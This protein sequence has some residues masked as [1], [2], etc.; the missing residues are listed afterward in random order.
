MKLKC[1]RK[2]IE[3]LGEGDSSI[4][5]QI[6]RSCESLRH[7]DAYITIQSYPVLLIRFA[8]HSYTLH[9]LF[10]FFLACPITRRSLSAHRPLTPICN[11]FSCTLYTS[12]TMP[13]VALWL[14]WLLSKFLSAK[15]MNLIM[16][17]IFTADGLVA[18]FVPTLIEVIL[19]P[20]T[21][22][23][24]TT[25]FPTR[26]AKL[27]RIFFYYSWQSISGMID[28]G[29]A[30][31]KV[32]VIQ[33]AKGVVLEIGAGLGVNIKYY[34]RELVN[35]LILVE[36]NLAMHPLLLAEANKYKYYEND[37]SLLLL[38]CGGAA[39][40]EKELEAAGVMANSIDTVACIHGKYRHT[41]DCEIA[42][43]PQSF[44]AS[45]NQ[46]LPSRCTSVY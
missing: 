21:Y 12:A 2:H 17:L 19:H 36:P 32:P 9:D 45:Q 35:Q 3:R 40:D 43:I 39:S 37:G 27:R 5:W 44:A 10:V 31:V 4:S 41:P 11:L 13:A 28:R 24:T 1:D 16:P 30:E 33:K 18:G 23:F 29:D 38:G 42:N 8:V 26:Y 7:T 22:I 25:P 15:A 46:Y 20:F 34:K 14:G 6:S